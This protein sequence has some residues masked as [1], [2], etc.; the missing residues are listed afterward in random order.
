MCHYL[1]YRINIRYC[2]VAT[3]IVLF[4]FILEM[5]LTCYC[6]IAGRLFNRFGFVEAKLRYTL[7]TF[8]G[9]AD[10]K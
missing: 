4:K 6:L 3:H 7:N 1:Y 8:D 5:A 2:L 9:T 10:C